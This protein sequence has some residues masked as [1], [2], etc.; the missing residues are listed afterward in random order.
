MDFPQRAVFFLEED[1]SLP[2]HSKPL[3]LE[4]VLFCPILKWMSDK[5]LAD[6]VQRF[7]AVSSP[8]FAQEVRACFPEDA[9]VTI[10]EQHRELLDFLNTPDPVAVFVRAALP[11][12]EAGPGFV[13]GA[14]GYELQA[15]WQEKMTNAVS[16]AELIPGWVPV[17]SLETVAE[18]EP[19]RRS[20]QYYYAEVRARKAAS[21]AN[22]SDMAAARSEEFAVDM[23]EEGGDTDAPIIRLLNSL[24]QRAAT[25]GASDIHIEPFEGETKVRMRIDGV[26]IDYVTLQR[27]LHQPLIARIKIMSNLDIAEHRVP[28]DGHFRARL[29]TGPDVNVRVSILPTVFGEKAVLRLLATNTRIEHADHFGMDDE[30]YKRFRP[31]LDR[32]NGIVYLTGPTGSGKTT[33]LYMVLQEVAQRQVNVSTIEDPVERNLDRINQTQV[34][35]VAGLTFESGLRALLRQDPDVIMVG[36]TRDAETASISVRAAITGHMVFSTL[37]T[38]DALSSIVRLEDMG[39]ERYMIANSLAGVVAQRLMRRVC[40]ACARKVP[41]T[42]AEAE[43]LG[44]GIPFVARGT[45]CPQCNGTGYKGRVAIHEMVVINKALRR[46]I[47]EG[48]SI[49]EMTDAAR[50]N[51]GMRSLRESAVQLVRDGVTTPEELLKITYFEE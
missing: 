13:Y 14:A 23:T 3:M 30:T 5:L 12:E 2:A 50:K 1:S 25:T 29:E 32:P 43:L 48:A 31:L 4:A 37:H 7:F 51:Q 6:G 16:A 33:T 10:S 9:D 42:E 11:M 41:V 17:F 22:S 49:E 36:E 34:N 20:I 19:L 38:N 27:A 28:Q 40:P 45:G 26:I 47:A 24:V 15:V 44:P 18:L 35:N 21:K 39:V 46:M 8:R